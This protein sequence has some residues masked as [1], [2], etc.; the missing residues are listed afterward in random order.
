MNDHEICWY[1]GEEFTVEP[2]DNSG[3]Y[4][5][6]GKIRPLCNDCFSK[7]EGVLI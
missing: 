7:V 4:P 5:I 1:C 2:D 6:L 3:Y